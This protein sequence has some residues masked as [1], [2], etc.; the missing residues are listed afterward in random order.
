MTLEKIRDIMNNYSDDYSNISKFHLT[1][2]NGKDK[3]DF[4]TSMKQSYRLIQQAKEL[5]AILLPRSV[6]QTSS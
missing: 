1:G 6:N 4:I 2:Q 5:L 3:Y